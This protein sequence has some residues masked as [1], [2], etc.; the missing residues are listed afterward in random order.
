[1]HEKNSSTRRKLPNLST[2]LCTEN[3]FA[4]TGTQMQRLYR[5]Q[6]HIQ[7]TISILKEA[8]GC[9]KYHQ[10]REDSS[11]LGLA[12]SPQ[13]PGG[14]TGVLLSNYLPKAGSIHRL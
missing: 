7:C 14:E 1:M 10:H 11:L 5:T 2:N 6:E 13:S 9:T 3:K 4:L 12:S 8:I